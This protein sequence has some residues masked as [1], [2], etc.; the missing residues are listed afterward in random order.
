MEAIYTTFCGQP[1]SWWYTA[2]KDL[3]PMAVAL[4]LG[5]FASYI[6]FRQWRTAV[7]KLKHDLFEKRYKIHEKSTLY[8]ALIC[9]ESY[10]KFDESLEF[11][12]S[13]S[14]AKFLFRIDIYEYLEN[15]Y[16]EGIKLLR[17]NTEYRANNNQMPQ[18]SI[19]AHYRR[20]N[21]FFAQFDE[22]DKKF[23]E[24]LDLSR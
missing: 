19:E 20:L 23:A 21:W 11:I 5:L 7:N 1:A 3:G 18:E 9:R 17:Y 12:H 4:A 14:S 6:A 13:I 15:L 8:V 24:Y 22:L 2:V 10:P 16:K